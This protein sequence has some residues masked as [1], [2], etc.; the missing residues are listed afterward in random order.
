MLRDI[1][2]LQK[3]ELESRLQ[4]TYIERKMSISWDLG[5]DLIK[6]ITGP[7]RAGK[8]FYGVHLIQ[9]T[10]SYGYINFDD[11]RLTAMEDYDEIVSAVNA[12]YGNSRYLL[13]DEIQNLPRW[14]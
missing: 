1:V 12:V 4:E 10:G 8:S 2:L 7:R 5:D 11:E 9:Q 13:F 3:R 14:E 6:I